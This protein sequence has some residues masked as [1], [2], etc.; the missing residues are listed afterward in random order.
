MPQLK[1]IVPQKEHAALILE[2]RRKPW[3]A[4]AMYTKV[5]HDVSKQ[6]EW[7]EAC[8]QCS[9][10]RHWLVVAGDRPIGLVNL[11]DI[12]WCARTCGNGY[13]IGEDDARPLAGF[14]VP[15][16]YN[17]V[18]FDLGMEVLTGE[19][20]AD[21]DIMRLNRLIGYE[22]TLHEDAFE[23]DGEMFDIIKLRL[24]RDDWMTKTRFHRYRADFPWVEKAMR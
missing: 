11:H 23:R 8:L 17:Y 21:N 1:F 10:Y 2:W 24:T 22:E 15:F 9:D 16:L 12:D 13:Y 20:I 18:F 19:V 3:V 7:L 6:E 14:A 5:D 4:R